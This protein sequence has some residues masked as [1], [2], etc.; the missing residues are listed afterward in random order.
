MQVCSAIRSAQEP[1]VDYRTQD[2]PNY[3][4]SLDVHPRCSWHYYSAQHR[5]RPDGRSRSYPGCLRLHGWPGVHTSI[6]AVVSTYP[7]I[8]EVR[9]ALQLS[10]WL[11]SPCV[12]VQLVQW[13]KNS[14]ASS[15][16]ASSPWSDVT[17]GEAAATQLS[18]LQ[19]ASGEVT[20]SAS[21]AVKPAAVGKVLSPT[22]AEA[23][24]ARIR[25]R[26]LDKH[27][28]AV[29]ASI[30]E[31]ANSSEGKAG[32]KLE[33]H[34]HAVDRFAQSAH[35]ELATAAAEVSSASIQESQVWRVQPTIRLT[36]ASTLAQA[37][38]TVVKRACISQGAAS[39]PAP[40]SPA[41]QC[42]NDK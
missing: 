2:R 22:E 23:A 9:W 15:A 10:C 13:D 1:A 16:T 36:S 31:A 34:A 3:C 37:N 39:T 42:S 27:R 35:A 5:D 12:V 33:Q 4:H 28:A 21:T 32:S 29:A 11:Q 20:A 19:E 14:V 17:A 7:S 30:D 24:A 18:G 40:E 8:E 6:R 26:I 38:L 25:E 41:R